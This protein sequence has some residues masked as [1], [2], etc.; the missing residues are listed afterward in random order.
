MNE[1]LNCTYKKISPDTVQIIAGHIIDNEFEKTFMVFPFGE[2]FFEIDF[3]NVY[4][5]DS[6]ALG[7]LKQLMIHSKT[8]FPV[9]INSPSAKVLEIL[10]MVKFDQLFEIR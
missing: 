3:S 4:D 7:I 1:S 10:T 6:H 9:V 2:F 8:G 5:L